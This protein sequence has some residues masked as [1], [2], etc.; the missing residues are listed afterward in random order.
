MDNLPRSRPQQVCGIKE[1]CAQGLSKLVDGHD[2]CYFLISL[3]V[4]DG[5][6]H[7]LVSF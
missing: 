1:I 7:D 6:A 5:L 4:S 3:D 2:E